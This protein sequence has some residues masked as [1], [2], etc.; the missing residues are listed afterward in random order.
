MFRF[1]YIFRLFLTVGILMVGISGCMFAKRKVF[2]LEQITAYMGQKYNDTFTVKGTD[3]QSSLDDKTLLALYSENL[4]VNIKVNYQSENGKIEE[5]LTDN[6]MSYVLK[7]DIEALLQPM[8]EEIYGTVKVFYVINGNPFFEPLG[9]ET[10]AD[11]L[12][13]SG[14]LVSLVVLLPPDTDRYQ[15]RGEALVQKMREEGYYPFLII[16]YLNDKDAYAAADGWNYNDYLVP[17]YELLRCDHMVEKYSSAMEWRD[18]NGLIPTEE[19]AS[20][21]G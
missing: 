2:T 19:T 5:A 1:R 12:L 10:T 20:E 8:A 13:T 21:A 9:P 11:N 7:P 3:L 17:E 15:K 16:L 14:E 4:G 6:Y 18:Q